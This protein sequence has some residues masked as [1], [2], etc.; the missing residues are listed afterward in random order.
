MAEGGRIEPGRHAGTPASPTTE[1]RRLVED[2][3][4]AGRHE[5]GSPVQIAARNFRLC[6]CC[7]MVP[8]RKGEVTCWS[9]AGWEDTALDHA[10]SGEGPEGDW[11][12]GD[13]DPPDYQHPDG[14]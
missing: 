9:C 13:D 2:G 3:G 4:Y 12:P 14:D 6:G 7:G 11:G 1:T 10:H 5:A 8:A